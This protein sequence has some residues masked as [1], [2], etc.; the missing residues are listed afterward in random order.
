MEWTPLLTGG[1][2]GAVVA[3][4]I[5]Y[6][7]FKSRTV[8]R[9]VHE[10]L[11][12]RLNDTSTQLRLAEER[13]KSQQEVSLAL[14]EKANQKEAELSGLL[15]R[16]ASLETTLQI[17]NERLKELAAT[18]NQQTEINRNQ[19]V[20]INQHQKQVVELQTQNTALVEKLDLQKNEIVEMQKTAHLQ[21]EKLAHQIFEE[22]SGKFT[23]ANKSNIEAILKPL[24]ENIDSFKK[25]VEETYDKESKQRFSLEEKVKDLIENTNKISQEAN[26]LASALKGQAKKQG[27]WGET[28]LERILEMSG[29]EKGREYF[30]QENLKD[31]EGNNVRPDVIVRLPGNRNIIIDSKVS[32]N[33]YIRYTEGESKEQ[34]DIFI[35]Q[36]LTAL[37]QHIDQL[38]TKKYHELVDGLDYILMF[39]PIEPAYMLAVQS[40]PHLWSAAYAKKIVLISPSILVPTMK[41]IADLWKKELQNKNALEIANEGARLYDK[42]VGFLESMEDLGKNI[43]RSQESYLKAVNQLKDGKGNLISRTDKLKKLG[44]KSAKRLPPTFQSADQEDEEPMGLSDHD[45]EEGAS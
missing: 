38:S 32:M 3:I 25:R 15:S 37:N 14:Q 9:E 20:E 31:E 42:F 28:I 34:Q 35:A 43:S 44:V 13:L 19:Q 5:V 1:C 4:I 2:V 17:N 45:E 39:I 36:H 18:L 40:D 41:I 7:L 33:A 11:T 12:A 23:E 6:L 8:P 24:G 10:S 29:L 21:F 26:N 16:T 30:V 22:K 27:D